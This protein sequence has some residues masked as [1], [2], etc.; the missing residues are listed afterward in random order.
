MTAYLL[1]LLAVGAGLVATIAGV[2]EAKAPAPAVNVPP[3]VY[4][5][6]ETLETSP[7]AIVSPTQTAPTPV[8]VTRPTPGC[9]DWVTLALQVGWQPSEM[10]QLDAILRAESSCQ[11]AALGDRKLGGS[12]GLLQIH[13]PSWGQPNKYNPVGW[14]QARGV[15]RSCLD[16]FD[17]ATNLYAGLLIW[18]HGGWQQWATYE[19]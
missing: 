18:R 5:S 17:P 19:P 14:L 11:P 7:E 10:P 16:L 8:P 1:K 15:I 2:S 13:C 3:A 9:S 12:Y 6:T 4:V